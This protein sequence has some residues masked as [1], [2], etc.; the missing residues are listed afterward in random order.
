MFLLRGA[1]FAPGALA[2]RACSFLVCADGRSF[3]GDVR[4]EIS[5][6][7]ELPDRF[8]RRSGL[9]RAVGFL[10]A[11]VESYVGVTRHRQLGCKWRIPRPRLQR[12]NPK[13]ESRGRLRFEFAVWHCLGFGIRIWDFSSH[14]Y[15]STSS[16]VVSPAKMLRKP[17]CRSV[18]MPSSIA[19]SLSVTV[20][21]RSL[22]SSR[23]GSVIFSNS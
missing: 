14:V 16:I 15:F 6:L 13:S 7:A 8:V 19:F 2:A 18:T 22:I 12:R 20:G 4:R 11:G 9:D 10:A 21:A 1:R 5:R 23:S 17:S 3:F